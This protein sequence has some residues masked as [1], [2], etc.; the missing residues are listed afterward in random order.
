MQTEGQ[1]PMLK[2]VVE[3]SGEM[4]M[5]GHVDLDG[6]YRESCVKSRKRQDRKT[7]REESTP[8]DCY[9]EV[10]ADLQRVKRLYVKEDKLEEWEEVQASGERTD[11]SAKTP[12]KS[13]IQLDT[14]LR[15]GRGPLCSGEEGGEE[16]L[17]VNMGSW[18]LGRDTGRLR[19]LAPQF[20]ILIKGAR[21]QYV[22]WATQD[23]EGLVNRLPNI[24]E[25]AGKW[26]K[27]LEEETSG[28]L[29][30]VIDMKKHASDSNE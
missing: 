7:D 20:P 12:V 17:S 3:V 1:F 19:D 30:S 14:T 15:T 21:G 22:P 5:E 29:L 10:R 28:K 24:H 27:V 16:D 23:L 11:R 18:K 13:Q 4:Q 8:L 26:I 9:K 25:G 6:D 2:G